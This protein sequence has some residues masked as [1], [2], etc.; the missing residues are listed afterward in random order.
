M[1]LQVN[2]V[3]YELAPNYSQVP[4]T[5]VVVGSHFIEL[6]PFIEARY[7]SCYLDEISHYNHFYDIGD[8]AWEQEIISELPDGCTA[9]PAS[10]AAK[11]I[12][13][14]DSQ[15]P[16]AHCPQVLADWLEDSWI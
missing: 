10:Q 2:A 6:T 5:G 9:I 11:S 15:W 14:A 8:M 4:G 13:W 7:I 1:F 3:Q 16:L 12:L